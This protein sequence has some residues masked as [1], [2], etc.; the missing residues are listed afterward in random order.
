MERYCWTAITANNTEF[1][2]RT[3]TCNDNSEL[4]FC[5]CNIGRGRLSGIP[6]ACF[7]LKKTS[8]TP[9]KRPQCGPNEF[10]VAI[11]PADPEKKKC[12]PDYQ[13]QAEKGPEILEFQA[14]GSDAAQFNGNSNLPSEPVPAF[15]IAM[16]AFGSLLLVVLVTVVVLLAFIS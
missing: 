16:L 15:A 7:P 12:C 14:V 11:Q 3:V 2:S 1:A 9:C 6:V 10:P 5:E 4:S 13:C 8:R